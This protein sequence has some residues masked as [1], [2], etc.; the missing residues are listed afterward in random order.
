MCVHLEGWKGTHRGIKML[1]VIAFYEGACV[2]ALGVGNPGES[3]QSDPRNFLK[4]NAKPN[5][6]WLGVVGMGLLGL[7]TELEA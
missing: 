3:M 7:G 4:K 6:P 1:C 5:S 2:C